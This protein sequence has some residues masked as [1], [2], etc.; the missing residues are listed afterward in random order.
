M[1]KVKLTQEKADVLE[2]VI[3]RVGSNELIVGMHAGKEVPWG[4]GEYVMNDF[5]LDTL[6]RALYIGYEVEPE[7]NV[8]DWVK[9]K[10]GKGIGVIKEINRMGYYTDFGLI[11]DHDDIRHATL[12]EIAKEKERKWWAKHG[13]SVWELKIDDILVKKDTHDLL[14]VR[15]VGCKEYGVVG[16]DNRN[17]V[18]G[19]IYWEE[20]MQRFK[21]VCFAEDRK[22]V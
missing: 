11:A 18:Y 7:F 15:N 5:S 22:D 6:I 4:Q 21:V 9:S 1:G 12:E 13:R 14:R 17:K 19:Q 3:T 8:D 20:I 16:L 10:H 2:G